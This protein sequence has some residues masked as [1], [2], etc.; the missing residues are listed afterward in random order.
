M[1]RNIEITKEV[2][3]EKISIGYRSQTILSI[4]NVQITV[5]LSTK[6]QFNPKHGFGGNII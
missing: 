6:F 2:L 3:F 5:M 1:G 4:M